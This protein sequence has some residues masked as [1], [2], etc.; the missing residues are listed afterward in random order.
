[1]IP[2]EICTR[3]NRGKG[4]EQGDALMPLLSLGQHQASEAVQRQLLPEERLLAFLDDIYT[5]AS[6]KRVG[7]VCKISGKRTV[8]EC[9][10]KHVPR[11]S[12]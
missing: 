5:V 6:P 11:W 9:V 8:Q 7:P 12:R 10:P 2:T 3:W 1:M 4:G